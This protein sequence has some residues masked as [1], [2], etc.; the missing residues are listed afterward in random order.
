MLLLRR[1]R[2][3]AVARARAAS[4]GAAQWRPPRRLPPK[5]GLYDP[6]LERDSCGV[7]MVAHLKGQASHE[8]VRD[9]NTMLVRMAHRGG[10]GC[11]PSSGDG[12]GML[13]GMPHAFLTEAVGADL[14][15]ALPAAGAFGAGNVFF[16]RDPAVVAECKAVVERHVSRLGLSLIGWRPVPVDNSALGPTSLESEPHTEML[17]VGGPSGGAPLPEGALDREL[18]RLRLAASN[19]IHATGGDAAADFYVCSLNTCARL[20]SRPRRGGR[21][22]RGRGVT[23]L[24]EC[25]C[26]GRL[27]STRASSRRS[28]R[29]PPLPYRHGIRTHPR[30]PRYPN[31]VTGA[32][33]PSSYLPISP[34]ISPYLTREQARAPPLRSPRRP[35][36]SS[37]PPLGRQSPAACAGVGLLRRPPVR[38]V[39]LAPRPRPLALLHEHLPLVGA[40]ATLPRPLPQR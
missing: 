39:H 23:H 16:P 28:R 17:L 24:A 37:R 26:V 38:A 36:P 11:E 22:G 29:A 7:G 18:Y 30:P 8:I 31:P 5:Q 20:V 1:P 32:R 19:E 3:T 14:G 27:L 13:T 9:A 15:V 10:C 35:L 4:S 40:R 12:A 34:R 21:G 2:R 33:G 6:A 25:A